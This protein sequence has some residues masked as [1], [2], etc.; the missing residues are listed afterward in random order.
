MTDLFAQNADYMQGV[1]VNVSR[2][3][4][5][6]DSAAEDMKQEALLSLSEA[7]KVYDP[8][9]NDT[10][11]Y[12]AT[13]FVLNHLFGVISRY[14][15]MVKVP[16]RSWKQGAR[17]HGAELTANTSSYSIDPDTAIDG[18]RLW[19]EARLAMAEGLTNKN[20]QAY[21]VQST[22]VY[23]RTEFREERATDLAT[24]FGTSREVIRKAR[25]RGAKN[26]EAWAEKIRSEC[27]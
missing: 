9:R 4:G 17:S 6:F 22:D 7:V 1:A 25:L 20:G 3:N 26:L 16:S 12:F 2:R 19:K 5:I 15:A 11:K 24:E 14:A 18:A 10:F 23:L 13:R 8:A 27:V 21:T